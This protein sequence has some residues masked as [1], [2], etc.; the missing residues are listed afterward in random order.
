MSA[1]PITITIFAVGIGLSMPILWA[2]LGELVAEQAGVINV[3]IEG[4]ML[5]SACAAAIF[6]HFNDSFLL[7]TLIGLGTGLLFGILLGWWYVFRGMNQIVTGIVFNLFAL[8]LTTSLF[9]S[10]TYL[11]GDLNATLPDVSVPVLNSI[12]W[13][14]EVLFEQDAMVYACIVAILLVWLLMSRTW[15]G[16]YV[17]AAGERP[18]AVLATGRDVQWVRFNATLIAC[19]FA[20]IAGASLIVAVAGAFNVNITVGMGFIALAVVVVARWRPFFVALVALGFGVTQGLQF[21]VDD[22]GPLSGLPNELWIALPYMIVILAL[23]LSRGSQ[24]PPALGI[25]YVNPN[26]VSLWQRIRDRLVSGRSDSGTPTEIPPPGQA[27][28]RGV[29]EMRGTGEDSRSPADRREP[30]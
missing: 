17:R 7:A 20:G 16:V 6:F 29:S 3:G 12:P 25:P 13:L 15:F 1:D 10:E 21:Q 14:G 26:A 19:G 18:S 8:G 24:Y 5:I 9:A 4:V 27:T 22:L 11:A 28:G 2:A 30:R 23:F